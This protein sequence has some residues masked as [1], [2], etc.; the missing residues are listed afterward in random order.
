MALWQVLAHVCSHTKPADFMSAS[1]VFVMLSG[2]SSYA[3]GFA[4]E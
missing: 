1:M 3:L 4:S 2:I